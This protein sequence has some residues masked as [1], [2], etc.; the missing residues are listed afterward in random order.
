MGLGGG[1]PNRVGER[2]IATKYIKI[3][4]KNC[5][6]DTGLTSFWHISKHDWLWVFTS[7]FGGTSQFWITWTMK[8]MASGT[9]G[10]PSCLSKPWWVVWLLGGTCHIPFATWFCNGYPRYKIFAPFIISSV[11]DWKPG[12]PLKCSSSFGHNDLRFVAALSGDRINCQLSFSIQGQ[13][14][15]SPRATPGAFDDDGQRL[16]PLQ[17]AVLYLRQGERRRRAWESHPLVMSK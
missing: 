17:P 16:G 2:G 1:S 14:Q 10:R 12:S 8:L 15:L 3:R 5:P 7:G 4:F 13:V 6:K 11:S 9:W